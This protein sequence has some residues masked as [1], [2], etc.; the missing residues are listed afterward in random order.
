ELCIRARS[1]RNALGGRIPYYMET[2]H[3]GRLGNCHISQYS[4]KNWWS[5]K[6][7]KMQGVPDPSFDY[8]QLG[9]SI[10][11][12]FH[13]EVIEG[14][15][16]STVKLKDLPIPKN[17]SPDY[18]PSLVANKDE[19]TLESEEIPII[20]YYEYIGLPEPVHSTELPPV[21]PPT[22]D[23]RIVNNDRFIY[24]ANSIDPGDIVMVLRSAT[25]NGVKKDYNRVIFNNMA[26]HGDRP[27]YSIGQFY[28]GTKLTI[29]FII[30][31]EDWMPIAAVM[32]LMMN[33][34][35]MQFEERFLSNTRN[36]T[37]KA[38]SM[39]FTVL[40]LVANT[41]RPAFMPLR[42]SSYLLNI[43]KYWRYTNETDPGMYWNYGRSIEDMIIPKMIYNATWSETYKDDTYKGYLP[44]PL[45]VY[46]KFYRLLG[47]TG[48][49]EDRSYHNN[50][51][52]ISNDDIDAEDKKFDVIHWYG[53]AAAYVKGEKAIGAVWELDPDEIDRHLRNTLAFGPEDQHYH[54]R[55][56]ICE[57]HLD[58]DSVYEMPVMPVRMHEIYNPELAAL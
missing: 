31:N 28:V 24:Y 49:M 53:N 29:D 14:D 47:F 39:T 8:A 54:G 20:I 13:T 30:A 36:G 19:Y 55:R 21:S 44:T 5:C 43:T 11:S 32:R 3:E 35:T 7:C 51:N 2:I 57:V 58:D 17:V 42:L 56:S 45:V 18:A 33:N 12:V 38:Y 22:S 23:V 48:A 9:G 50:V 26:S 40:D 52:L 1:P 37:R 27:T 46:R 6:S 15:I 34:P 4:G 25:Y 10:Y 16:G 41:I